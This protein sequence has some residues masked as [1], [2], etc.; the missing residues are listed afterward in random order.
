MR[1]QFKQ[2]DTLFAYFFGAEMAD[3]RQIFEI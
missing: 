2:K 3:F 1:I